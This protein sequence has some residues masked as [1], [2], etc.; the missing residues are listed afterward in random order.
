[1]D[2]QAPVLVGRAAHVHHVRVAGV[3]GRVRAEVHQH[4]TAHGEKDAPLV[5]TGCVGQRRPNVPAIEQ[6]REAQQRPW[7][8]RTESPGKRRPACPGSHHLRLES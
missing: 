6:Q 7:G 1:M 2:V 4:H 3:V 5:V 8:R